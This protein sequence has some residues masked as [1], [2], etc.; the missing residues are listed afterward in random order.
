MYSLAP[1]PLTNCLVKSVTLNLRTSN[2]HGDYPKYELAPVRMSEINCE[3]HSTH[4][5]ITG[6]VHDVTHMIKLTTASHKKLRI[7]LG[8]Q[9]ELTH[10]PYPTLCWYRAYLSR[11]LPDILHIYTSFTTSLSPSK[12]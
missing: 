7:G 5:H 11:T 3:L 6:P 1:F 12:S 8:P 2:L 9:G 10:L 4:I